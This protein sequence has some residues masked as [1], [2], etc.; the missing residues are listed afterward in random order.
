MEL[1]K[2][3][4]NQILE[5]KGRDLGIKLFEGFREHQFGGNPKRKGIAAEELR[6]RSSQGRGIRVRPSL[7]KRYEQG[8]EHLTYSVRSFGQGARRSLLLS[9]Y[10]EAKREGRAA[11]KR[12]SALWKKAVGMELA[13]RESGIGVLA[14]SFLWY[15][16]RSNNS[17]GTFLV[18]NR[19]GKPLGYVERSENA[20]RIVG[21]TPGLSAVDAK[22]SVVVG[23]INTAT[24]DMVEYV[25]RKERELFNMA[26]SNAE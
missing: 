14:A 12:R 24:A 19:T 11:R 15:R 3:L 22:H 21:E 5:K 26:F 16:K 7:R 13:A 17:M 8:R 4:P 18:P 10:R 6:Q 20:L 2:K 23:A 9:D 25:T 1:S